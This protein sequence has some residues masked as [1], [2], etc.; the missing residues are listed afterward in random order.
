MKKVFVGIV[1][2]LCIYFVNNVYG[3]RNESVY[4]STSKDNINPNDEIFFYMSMDELKLD[5]NETLEKVEFNIEYDKNVFLTLEDKNI[6]SYNK[7]NNLEFKPLTNKVVITNT[8][9]DYDNLFVFMLKAKE[10]I[11]DATTTIKIKN[12][13]VTSNNL[14]SYNL[15]NATIS[16]D[17][18]NINQ[19]S[20]ESNILANTDS[21][22]NGDIRNNSKDKNVNLETASLDALNS[23][24]DKLQSFKNSL[25][26][27]NIFSILKAPF[28]VIGIFIYAFLAVI[29]FRVVVTVIYKYIHTR[30]QIIKNRKIS[31][32]IG[33]VL[34][35]MNK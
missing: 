4:L 2:C 29:L 27:D 25:S 22:N 31:K 17:V 16:L 23:V 3:I 6:S 35:D 26:S 9:I 33:K 8:Y 19:S 5:E 24:N 20:V 12:I 7:Y 1:L 10:N 11:K 30:K 32:R 34:S 15:S 21:S 14:K 28:S 18:E 13:K